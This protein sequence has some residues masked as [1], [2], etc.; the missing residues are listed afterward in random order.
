[1]E[2]DKMEQLG[3]PKSLVDLCLQSSITRSDACRSSL[4]E[5]IELW[6]HQIHKIIKLIEMRWY[7]WSSF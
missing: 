1:M 5:R 7:L 2:S 6:K 3:A 4:L